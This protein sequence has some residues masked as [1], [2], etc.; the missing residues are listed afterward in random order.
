MDEQEENWYMDDYE[1]E[2]EL[3]EEVDE[4]KGDNDLSGNYLDDLETIEGDDDYEDVLFENALSIK[5]VSS[6]ILSCTIPV[7]RQAYWE[8]LPHICHSNPTYIFHLSW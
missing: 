1:E 2:E 4:E 8:N 7:L 6:E 5:S 3:L